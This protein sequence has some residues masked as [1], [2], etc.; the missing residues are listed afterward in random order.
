MKNM[1][2]LTSI[3][4]LVSILAA[5]PLLADKHAHSKGCEHTPVIYEAP[6]KMKG[7]K[8]RLRGLDMSISTIGNSAS[9]AKNAGQKDGESE[10]FEIG[11]KVLVIATKHNNNDEDVPTTKLAKQVL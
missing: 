9:F 6:K 4:A 7:S 8:N 1:K 11:M 3:F 2:M 10:S 5:G